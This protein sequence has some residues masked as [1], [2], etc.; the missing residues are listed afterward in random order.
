MISG[1]LICADCAV[2]CYRSS[3]VWQ[4]RRDGGDWRRFDAAPGAQTVAELRGSLE[5]DWEV[6]LDGMPGAWGLAEVYS[7][8]R[9]V[10]VPH[11]IGRV[12][13]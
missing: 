13:R 2:A 12:P 8:G 9:G 7:D 4:K 6:W 5:L 1:Q 11:H 3:S 10:C